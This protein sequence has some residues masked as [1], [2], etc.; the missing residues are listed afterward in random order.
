MKLL[1]NMDVPLSPTNQVTYWHSDSFTEFGVP[2]LRLFLIL[3]M[4]PLKRCVATEND[5]TALLK[6]EAQN[7]SLMLIVEGPSL[8]N[9][10]HQFAGSCIEGNN[11]I[12]TYLLVFSKLEG[13]SSCGGLRPSAEAFFGPSGKKKSFLCS[14]CLFQAIFGA[15]Q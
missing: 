13:S 6:K 3:I 1:L 9:F 11:K 15:P 2:H 12:T 5:L 8:Q 7:K 4:M 14:F 10:N